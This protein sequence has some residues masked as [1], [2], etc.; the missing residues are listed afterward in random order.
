MSGKRSS[1]PGDDVPREETGWLDDLRK[2]KKGGDD[3]DRSDFTS[4]G[5]DRWAKLSALGDHDSPPAEPRPPRESAPRRPRPEGGEPAGRRRAAE[6]ESMETRRARMEA[7]AANLIGRRSRP[8]PEPEPDRRSSWAAE[9]GPSPSPTPRQLVGRRA[10]PEPEPDAAEAGGPPRPSR[11]RARAAEAGGPPRPQRP[12]AGGA[13]RPAR[14]S[15][16][17][18]RRSAFSDPD[19]ISPAPQRTR[20]APRRPVDE[21]RGRRVADRRAHG[22]RDQRARRRSDPIDEPPRRRSLFGDRPGSNAPVSSPPSDEPRRRSTLPAT[23]IGPARRCAPR[24]RTGGVR[25]SGF[26]PAWAL[27]SPPPPVEE[28]RR[29]SPF[30]DRPVPNIPVTPPHR[31]A[32]GGAPRPARPRRRVTSRAAGRLSP[33]APR[34]APA[35]SSRR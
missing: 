9:R 30:G 2:A 34:P 7:A 10:R 33:R 1:S 5:T 20:R 13:V 27:L 14:Q 6:A 8:E 22:R 18:R 16:E 35:R 32:A 15:S 31:G 12:R 26:A 21:P 25:P 28:T 24:R 4:G 19:P 29:R 17:P 23:A 11:A 3:L